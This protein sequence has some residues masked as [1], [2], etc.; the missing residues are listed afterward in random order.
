MSKGGCIALEAAGTGITALSAQAVIR[1]L[2]GQ[3]SESLRSV[4]AWVP[5]GLSGRLALLVCIGLA[6]A[7]S[8]ARAH[9]RLIRGSR[10]GR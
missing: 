4:L 5:G 10:T 7:A 6:G 1:A 3:E 2:L 9:T 8:G